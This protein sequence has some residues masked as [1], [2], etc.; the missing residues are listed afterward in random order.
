M[1]E[2]LG[3]GKGS[4]LFKIFAILCPLYRLVRNPDD[5][6]IIGLEMLLSKEKGSETIYTPLGTRPRRISVVS[7]KCENEKM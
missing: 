3:R 6:L 1:G 2:D 4:I 5:Y 7:D